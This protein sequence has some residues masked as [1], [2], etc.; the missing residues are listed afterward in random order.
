M[1]AA[2]ACLIE[3]I[4]HIA[5]DLD[6]SDGKSADADVAVCMYLWL[7]MSHRTVLCGNVGSVVPAGGFCRPLAHDAGHVPTVG[8]IL[9]QRCC[10]L[11]DSR[12]V[13]LYCSQLARPQGWRCFLWPC[14]P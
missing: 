6:T 14:R 11:C 12:C 4:R 8:Q 3:A 5:G 1:V 7:L 13:T 9:D 2:L 10:L